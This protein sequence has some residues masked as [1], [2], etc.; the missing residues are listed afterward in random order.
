MSVVLEG[1][2]KSFGRVA[3]LRDVHLRAERG[4][5]MALLG[6]SGCGK[7]TLLRVIAGFE[8]PDVGRIVIDDADVTKRAVGARDIGFVFQGYALFPHQTV[9]QNIAFALTVR[10]RPSREIRERVEEL[11][12]LVGLPGFD[13]RR[14]HELSG[15]QRQRVAL[16]MFPALVMEHGL[17]NRTKS[18]HLV[19][20]CSADVGYVSHETCR[21]GAWLTHCDDASSSR[22]DL[23]H[24]AAGSIGLPSGGRRTMKTNGISTNASAEIRYVMSA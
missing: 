23:V 18:A 21:R 13:M 10:K 7:T 9:A 6:P 15:G 14:P 12:E 24:S 11:L 16:A 2:S 5:L 3:A 17:K 1:I 19:G 20:F 22:A 4:T 8:T